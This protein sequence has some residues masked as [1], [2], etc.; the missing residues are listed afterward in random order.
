M[1]LDGKTSKLRNYDNFFKTY[2]KRIKKER[3]GIIQEKINPE[4]DTSLWRSGRRVSK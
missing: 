4:S 3:P 2:L 1:T